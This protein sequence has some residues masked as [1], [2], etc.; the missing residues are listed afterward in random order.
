[1]MTGGV[2]SRLVNSMEENITVVMFLIPAKKIWDTLEETYGHE[3]N[4][5]R[6]YEIYEKFFSL[7]QKNCSVKSFIHRFDL[8]WMN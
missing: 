2:I 6:V 3:K 7:Q 8:L 4:I 5:P 1:M